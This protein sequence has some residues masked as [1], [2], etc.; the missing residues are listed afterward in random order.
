MDRSSQDEKRDAEDVERVRAD[1]DRRCG[2]P[3]RWKRPAGMLTVLAAL[4]LGTIGACIA[5]TALTEYAHARNFVLAASAVVA[6]LGTCV[7]FW[8]ARSR[9]RW[10]A[11][12]ALAILALAAP[13]SIPQMSARTHRGAKPWTDTERKSPVP[14]AKSGSFMPGQVALRGQPSSPS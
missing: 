13:S 8:V 6:A 1:A 7:G 3:A 4:A 11:I 2:A 12:L 9:R 10:I 5:T 14:P